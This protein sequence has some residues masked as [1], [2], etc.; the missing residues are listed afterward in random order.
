MPNLNPHPAPM[1]N[2]PLIIEAPK[3]QSAAPVE[4]TPT[5]V[6]ADSLSTGEQVQ[7]APYTVKRG[8][9]L[10][11][12][13]GVKLGDPQKWPLLFALNQNQIKNP[14]LIYPGQVLTIP[15]KV[16]VAPPV[17]P[18]T[19]PSPV[20]ASPPVVV[21]EPMVP[22]EPVQEKPPVQEAPPAPPAAEEPVA[23]KPPSELP[24][25][26]P[27]SPAVAPPAHQT[28]VPG[29]DLVCPP[30]SPPV[31]APPAEPVPPPQGVIG[32][33]PVAE[34]KSSGVGKA[35]MIGGTLGTVATGAV[36]IGITRSLA[37]PAANLGGY[38]TAQVVAKGV[39]SVIGKVGLKLPT[40]PALTRIISK[41]GGPKAAG[42]VTALAV[43]AVVAGVAAG[44][45]YLYNKAAGQPTAKQPNPTPANP[46]PQ[47]PASTPTAPAQPPRTETSQVVTPSAS[48]SEQLKK[49]EQSLSQ[50]SYFGYGSVTH[51]EEV[52]QLSE[53]LWVGATEI[54][55]RL[56]LAKTLV[57]HGQ[58]NEL[59]R[60]MGNMGVSDLEVAQ[61]MAQPSFPTREFMAGIDDNKATLILI[62]LS[63][64][65]TTGEPETAR[66]LKEIASQF[67][68][69]FRD[70]ETPFARLKAHHEGQ[71]SW[72]LLPPDVRSAIDTLLQ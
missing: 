22:A 24:E 50:K 58:A 56:E 64:V 72:N 11:D 69:R 49:L 12:I 36:L 15:Q 41:V 71:G 10:W 42:A 20:D 54:G 57:K 29:P 35:A 46:T 51:P 55:Q 31:T 4:A 60:I 18:P 38:A 47:A 6:W 25:P 7:M 39:N 67:N 26:T 37:P 19:L 52:S 62:S 5:T 27:E 34:N 1:G 17:P 53:Q 23:L 2:A 59:G 43:G 30:E 48:Q 3:P 16:E 45:Y 44:G 70:R 13:A 63:N 21:E 33:P 28:P 8:D 66:L 61:L 9:T 14:D 68:G 65:S 40:G 32:Q